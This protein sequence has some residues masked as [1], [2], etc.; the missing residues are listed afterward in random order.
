VTAY[1]APALVCFSGAASLWWL[2]LLRPGF[3]HCFVALRQGPFWVVVDPL[4]HRTVLWIEAVDNLAGF[5]RQQGLTVLSTRLRNPP[6]RSAPWRPFTCVE[7]VKRL[8]GVHWP[9]VLTPWQLY[10]ALQ[11]EEKIP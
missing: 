3:R 8:L 10:R 2:R 6:H 4:S 7:A 1:P 11:N 5:Y 9:W